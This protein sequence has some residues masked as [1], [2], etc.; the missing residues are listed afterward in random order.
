MLIVL[1]FCVNPSFIYF[2]IISR[3]VPN[4]IF[5][6]LKYVS[7]F[8][9]FLLFL[10][11]CRC[12]LLPPPHSSHPLEYI[13]HKCEFFIYFCQNIFVVRRQFSSVHLEFSRHNK[14]IPT[15]NCEMNNFS[16]KII[17]RS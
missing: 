15:S 16:A 14:Q 5:G 11:L 3:C 10:Y 1:F 2:Y 7:H 17:K 8:L 4:I 9:W 12:L 6:K 13:A